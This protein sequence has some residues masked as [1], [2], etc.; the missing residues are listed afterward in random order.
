MKDHSCFVNFFFPFR[1]YF[2]YLTKFLLYFSSFLLLLPLLILMLLWSVSCFILRIDIEK[3]KKKYYE[4]M[5][6]S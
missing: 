2:I 6:G 5:D 4:D 1:K 3:V